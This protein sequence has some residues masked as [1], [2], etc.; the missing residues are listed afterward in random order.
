MLSIMPAAE[1]F[2]LIDEVADGAAK[3]VS[4]DVLFASIRS[5]VRRVGGGA[6]RP[7]RRGEGHVHTASAGS[8]PPPVAGAV[9]VT[10]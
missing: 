5:Q 1:P 3:P 10:L 2:W 6:V 7:G 9:G 4:D 8:A